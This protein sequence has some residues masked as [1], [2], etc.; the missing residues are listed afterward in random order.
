MQLR[1]VVRPLCFSP[2]GD[3]A[4]IECSAA[5]A[6][7]GLKF[8]VHRLHSATDVGES[9]PAPGELGLMI[10][11]RGS[12][13][14]TLRTPGGDVRV[15]AHAGTV[16]LL[17]GERRPHVLDIVGDAEI[18]AFELS[19][20]WLEYVPVEA[21]NLRCGTADGGRTAL[22]LVSAMRDEVAGGCRT[23]R[24]YAESL[25]L[26][27]LS[28]ALRLLPPG[29][30]E[31]PGAA[32]TAAQRQ[33]VASYIHDHLDHDLGLITLAALAGM[34]PRQFSERFRNAFG[35]TPH[36]YVTRLRLQEAV[37]LLAAGRHEIAEIALR[38]GFS[39]QSHF[40]TA[41][42]EAFGETPKR[43]TSARRVVEK[44]V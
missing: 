39:S 37:R 22:A 9:G 42:R 28:Y 1:D 24:L 34:K 44:R 12:Y 31:R 30:E 7:S 27:V 21:T 6:W 38:V 19:P 16:A 11:T 18:A 2:A 23:G 17:S 8:E 36:R 32:L 13:A 43:F 29:E 4:P 5:T 10:V 14:T 35:T 33:R 15:S 40:T 3:L 41:F 25:S 26:A 20:E